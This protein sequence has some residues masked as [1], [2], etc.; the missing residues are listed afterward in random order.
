MIEEFCLKASKI[1]IEKIISLRAIL[2]K[3]ATLYTKERVKRLYHFNVF[4]IV[5]NNENYSY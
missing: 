3:C 4:L 1:S 2:N 5:S